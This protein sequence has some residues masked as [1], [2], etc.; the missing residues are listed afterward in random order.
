MDGTTPGPRKSARVTADAPDALGRADEAKALREK[1]GEAF[2]FRCSDW[3]RAK[4]SEM[5]L[6][7]LSHQ[8]TP[9]AAQRRGKLGTGRCGVQAR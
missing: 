8:H 5:W 6:K 1:Y 3:W 4:P 9:N 2:R 7:V